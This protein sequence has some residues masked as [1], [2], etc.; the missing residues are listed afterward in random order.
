MTQE[1]FANFLS[2]LFTD[3]KDSTNDRTSVTKR[4]FQAFDQNHDGKID[5]FEFQDMWDRWVLPMTAPSCAFIVVDVQ[6]DFISGT[7]S[8]KNETTGQDP[9]GVIPVIN[10]LVEQ[11]PWDLVVYSIDWHPKNHISFFE[12]RGCHAFHETCKISAKDVKLFDTVL[13]KDSCSACGYTEQTLWPSHCMQGTWG[14][15]LH[16]DLKVADKSLKIYKGINPDVGSYSAF[17]DNKKCSSTVLQEELQSRGI[18]HTFVCGLAYDVCV[19]FTATHSLELG[20]RTIVID[21]GS[22]GTSAEA[23]EKVKAK[24]RSQHCIMVKSSQVADIAAGRVRLLELG[25][26]TAPIQH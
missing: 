9:E 16:K 12:N 23:I 26:Q 5:I 7:L 4:L 20:Y 25:L 1:D 19:A 6:N 14:A 22:C 21:D 13:F 8:L 2:Q 18:T 10:K 3:Y 15:E 11:V 24:L 17:W